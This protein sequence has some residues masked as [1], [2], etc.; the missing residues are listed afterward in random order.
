MLH[1]DI[2]DRPHVIPHPDANDVHFRTARFF[3]LSNDFHAASTVR[4]HKRHIY[5]KTG[6]GGQVELIS[7][8]NDARI[9][10]ART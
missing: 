6:T 8:H 7:A 9:S 10:G 2:V 3:R 1:R 4:S 5:A